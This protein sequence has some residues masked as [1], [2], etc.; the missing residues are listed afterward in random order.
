MGLCAC[1]GGTW[2]NGQADYR[3]VLS[4]LPLEKVLRAI[5]DLLW[6]L[7]YHAGYEWALEYV[8]HEVQIH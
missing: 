4:K 2:R 1:D 8:S 5:N 3:G 6:L 7:N